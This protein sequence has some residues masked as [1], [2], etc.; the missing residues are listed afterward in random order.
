M[1]NDFDSKMK[2]V[3]TEIDEIDNS[4]LPLI[5][6]RMQISEKVA[7]IKKAAKKPIFDEN[8]EK[9]ILETIRDKSGVYADETELVYRSI[10]DASKELQKKNMLRKDIVRV[11][12][13]EQI[14]KIAEIAEIIWHNTYDELIGEDQTNYM[15][16]KFQSY[17]AIKNQIANMNYHYYL[18][19]EKDKEVGFI[20]FVPNHNKEDELFLSKIYIMPN[21]TGRG[22]ASKAINFV[23]DIAEELGLAKI[24]LT[25][26]KG[27][28][29]AITVY[30]H[31]GFEVIDSVETDIGAGYIMDD[32]IMSL[33]V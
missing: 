8:R 1:S 21:M 6:K 16:E 28:S 24:W 23:I 4:L 2:E 12:S 27:N 29:H 20:G 26:N 30:E 3:R 5:I 32:Y 7:E 11:E 18:M 31:F 19:I 13:D 17:M 15:I 9:A 14:Q 25:V 22:L 33:N 10:M